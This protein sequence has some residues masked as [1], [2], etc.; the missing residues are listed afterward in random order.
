MA[1]IA[2]D[3]LS[4]ELVVKEDEDYTESDRYEAVFLGDSKGK[5]IE[6]KKEDEDNREMRG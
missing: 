1:F 2:S 3:E 6:V 5:G 4:R